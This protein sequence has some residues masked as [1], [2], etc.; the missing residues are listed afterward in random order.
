MIDRI[1]IGT[2]LEKIIEDEL[3]MTKP[4]FADLIDESVNVVIRL[5][6]SEKQLKDLI[7]LD[8]ICSAS[9]YSLEDF[10]D[11]DLPSNNAVLIKRINYLLLKIER[12]KDLEF[13]HRMIYD[14]YNTYK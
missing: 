7:V 3:K 5:V 10:R 1:K 13:I 9:G 12:K 14:F 11:K 4:E 8:K 6:R 2:K